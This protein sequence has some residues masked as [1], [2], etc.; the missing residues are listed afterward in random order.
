MFLKFGAARYYSRFTDEQLRELLKHITDIHAKALPHLEAEIKKRGISTEDIA[1]VELERRERD[2]KER[3]KQRMN[4][5]KELVKTLS[6]MAFGLVLL[7]LV[8]KVSLKFV[9]AAILYFGNDYD[10]N[11]TIQIALNKLRAKS[12]IN[13]DIS[14]E[15]NLRVVAKRDS[16]AI[17]YLSTYAFQSV[18]V[19]D[20]PIYFAPEFNDYC[21]TKGVTVLAKIQYRDIRTDEELFTHSCSSLW[22]F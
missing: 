19:P 8:G 7:W 2:K 20:R 21:H 22:P 14:D 10:S 13:F 9:Y 16:S 3:K 4:A 6:L 15:R 1:K 11:L 5:F 17:V 12:M 18:P